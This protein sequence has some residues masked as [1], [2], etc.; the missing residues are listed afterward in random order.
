MLFRSPSSHCF[1]PGPV[2]LITGAAAN[3]G[4]LEIFQTPKKVT[5]IYEQDHSVR[6]IFTDGR[7]HPKNLD[8]SW[9][10]HSTGKW[11][12]DTLVVDTVGIREE[13]WL[14]GAG[15]A[16]SDQ[17]HV[18]ERYRR[19]SQDRL[20]I[21]MTLTDPKTFTKPYTMN[22]TYHWRPDLEIFENVTCDER[23]RKGLFF[24]EGPGGL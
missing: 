22:V 3:S 19:P 9:N 6:Q 17:L 2:R 11:E 16:H 8:L 10:G 14:D 21:T 20:E 13:T 12:G 24:G 15:H 5:I 23:Y 1:P 4:P 18:V 7:E